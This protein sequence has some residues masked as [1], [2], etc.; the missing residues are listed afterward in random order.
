MPWG[1]GLLPRFAPPPR[2]DG[3][4]TDADFAE[5]WSALS[6]QRAP[7]SLFAVHRLEECGDEAVRR[8]RA[9]LAPPAVPDKPSVEDLIG[10]LDAEEFAKRERATRL[11]EEQGEAIVPK[12]RAALK[13]ARSAE[14]RR[15]IEGILKQA[16]PDDGLLTPEY[17]RALRAMTVLNR[18]NTPASRALLTEIA[19]GPVGRPQTAAAQAVLGLTPKAAPKAELR[20]GM[21]LGN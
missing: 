18:I 2:A 1:R 4:G 6:G 16:A 5:L 21:G 10:Q 11:L 9:V 15:R 17:L 19:K 20:G 8:L 13:V 12:L 7:Q 14:V 3:V